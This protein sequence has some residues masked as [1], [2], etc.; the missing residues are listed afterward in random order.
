MLAPE[1]ENCNYNQDW[2]NWLRSVFAQ[3]TH[4]QKAES[5]KAYRRALQETPSADT[6][7]RASVKK[8]TAFRPF[9]SRLTRP[10]EISKLRAGVP[11]TFFNGESRRDSPVKIWSRSATARE[12]ATATNRVLENCGRNF[13]VRILAALAL[14]S[15]FLHSLALNS[16]HHL[17]VW[18]TSLGPWFN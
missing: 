15:F 11:A 8:V 2:K 4:I 13:L 16:I 18:L 1:V 6:S 12:T 9:I 5:L 3:Q 14:L 7:A 10:V 17:V